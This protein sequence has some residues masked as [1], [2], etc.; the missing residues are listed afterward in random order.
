MVQGGDLLKLLMSQNQKRKGLLKEDQVKVVAKQLFQAIDALHSQHIIHRD[1][2]CENVL[3]QNAQYNY[4]NDCLHIKL[5]D[6][7]F[8][9]KMPLEGLV[10]RGAGT[11]FYMA[12]EMI[13]KKPYDYKVDVWSASII[14]Y[15]MLTGKMPYS[16]NTF[17]EVGVKQDTTNPMIFLRKSKV[18]TE[19]QDFI[20]RGMHKD[21]GKRATVKELLSHEWL[22]GVQVPS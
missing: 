22:R 6:F 14:I 10:A 11:R 18:S 8:A 4:S 9:A 3:I 2:K 12:P 21:C 16:G 15:I 13:K 17:Q 5:A 7:G 20:E 1:I 19:A